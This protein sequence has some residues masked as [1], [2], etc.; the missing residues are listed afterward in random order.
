VSISAREEERQ[1][2]HL[3][4]R[5]RLETKFDILRA[6]Q[7]EQGE[8]EAR[9]THI[10]YKANISWVVMQNYLD[11]LES[12]ELID[13][14]PQRSGHKKYSLTAKGI[15]CLKNNAYREIVVWRKKI[16]MNDTPCS[17]QVLTLLMPRVSR[18]ISVAP[19]RSDFCLRLET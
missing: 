10:M 4:R 3:K 12:Q 14:V 19:I 11:E 7:Q 6:I 8:G 15:E 16:W 5:S 17:Y 13:G 9:P 18:K 2:S 1:R